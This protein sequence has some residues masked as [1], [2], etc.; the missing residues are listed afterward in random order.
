MVGGCIA[1][2]IAII[3][4]ENDYQLT[5]ENI[6]QFGEEIMALNPR[7]LTFIAACLVTSMAEVLV[8]QVDNLILPMVMYS[9]LLGIPKVL[10]TLLAR[11]PL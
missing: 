4:I 6:S 3:A 9:A 7:H 1:A 5:E 2:L 10:P 8:D 11:L